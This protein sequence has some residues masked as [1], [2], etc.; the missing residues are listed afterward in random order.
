MGYYVLILLIAACGLLLL[1]SANLSPP[2]VPASSEQPAP[3]TW[4]YR[5]RRGGAPVLTAFYM[6]IS[7]RGMIGGI[8]AGLIAPQAPS[9]AQ[10]ILTENSWR[11]AALCILPVGD[12]VGHRRIVWVNRDDGEPAGMGGVV[13]NG[14]SIRGLLLV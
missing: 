9:C 3:P 12:D 5:L 2:A 11:T 1:R 10:R 8:V 4:R 14:R 6:W 7:V 13:R